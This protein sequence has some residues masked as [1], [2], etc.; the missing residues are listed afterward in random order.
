V[1]DEKDRLGQT[2]HQ[3]EKALEDS[4]ARKYDEE[5]IAK[6]REKYTKPIKCPI[7]GAQLDARAAIG[8]GG[9]AC[10]LRHGAWLTAA[11]LEALRVRL[12]SAEAAHHAEL[13][14]KVFEAVK[15]IVEGLRQIHPKEIDCPDCGARLEARAAEASG[16]V[17]LGGIAC[18]NR[19]GAWLDQATLEE[20]RGRL[21]RLE[22]R[23]AR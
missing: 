14:E 16:E 10:P 2:L 22:N 6:L 18:P 19:H 12:E 15:E 1:S 21:D 11:T 5:I 8:L 3:R 7:C 17:G 23:S 20:V 4:W 9:M 13:G